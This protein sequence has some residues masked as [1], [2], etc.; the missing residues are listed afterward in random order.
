MLDAGHFGKR[1]IRRWRCNF[2]KTTFCEPHATVGTHYIAPEKAAQIIPMMM[3]GTSLRAIS[4]L[5][6]TDL[7][8]ILS[9][10]ETAGE[11]CRKLWDAYVTGIRTEFVQADEIW[12]FSLPA[13]TNGFR[14]DLAHFIK[15]RILPVSVGV[16]GHLL[17]DLDAAELNLR[18]K[19]LEF[20]RC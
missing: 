9:L 5:T 10:L 19:A 4:R 13:S 6:D 16:P 3:E 11:R 20:L 12:T 14:N 8:T 18:S 2:C 7:K 17:R 15:E 1:R